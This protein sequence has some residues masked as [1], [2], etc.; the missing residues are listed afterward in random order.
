MVV[1][2]ERA[3]TGHWCAA[4]FV[5]DAIWDVVGQREVS[6]RSEVAGEMADVAAHEDEGR[7]VGADAGETADVPEAVAGCVEEVEGAVGEVVVGAERANEGRRR[8]GELVVCAIGE[9]GGGEGGADVGG[10]AGKDGWGGRGEAGAGGEGGGWGKE[11]E[12]ANVVPVVVGPDNGR[13]RVE[14]DV[15]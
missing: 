1:C 2:E 11:G 8:K 13:D 3:G 4:G 7:W 10:I 12:V 5:E 15:F 6:R 14:V 9:V